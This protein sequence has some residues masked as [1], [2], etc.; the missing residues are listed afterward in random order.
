MKKISIVLCLI[1][2]ITVTG[3][4]QSKEKVPR[5][6]YITT[7]VNFLKHYIRSDFTKQPDDTVRVWNKYIDPN[8]AHAVYLTDY[9]CK[10][11]KLNQIKQ[12]IYDTDGEKI[13][14]EDFPSEWKIILPETVG[15]Q[16][17]DRVCGRA[18]LSNWAEIKALNANLRQGIGTDFP[19]LRIAKKGEQFRI[20]AQA[21]GSPWY[22][23]V[24]PETQEDFWVHRS[25]II[26]INKNQDEK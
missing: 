6:L 21:A 18:I 1:T 24:D 14:D 12:V 19:V 15:E 23:I 10:T 25:T 2:F 11:N 4:S 26:L 7:Q 8:G 13:S 9:N 22:N 5:W 3:N 20:V 17:L 16:I